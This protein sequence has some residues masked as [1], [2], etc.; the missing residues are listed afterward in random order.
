MMP[1]CIFSF[2]HPTRQS[3]NGCLHSTEYRQQFVHVC[4]FSSHSLPFY[5]YCFFRLPPPPQLLPVTGVEVSGSPRACRSAS[6]SAYTRIPLSS[7]RNSCAPFSSNANVPPCWM[8]RLSSEGA[9]S[10]H[11][12]STAI[13]FCR[14][15]VA[16]SKG[17]WYRS[18][19]TSN[20]FPSTSRR[21][22]VA[23]SA[24]CSFDPKYPF[25]TAGIVPGDPIPR[26]MK[27]SFTYGFT[28]DIS[29]KNP[30][31]NPNSLYTLPVSSQNSPETGKPFNSENRSPAS[32]DPIPTHSK[33]TLPSSSRG[34]R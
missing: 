28:P 4:H 18:P 5:L 29:P 30:E 34:L 6:I 24:L 16:T 19:R 31:L 32:L 3:T 1:P 12:S 26:S 17:L 7:Y 9:K 27:N 2:V 25:R 8:I 23:Q 33:S 20:L 13:I 14:R 11:L 21:H 15:T 10:C 22:T